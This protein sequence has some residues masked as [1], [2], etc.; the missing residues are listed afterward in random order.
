MRTQA[1]VLWERGAPWSI[2]DVDLAPPTGRGVLVELAASG[3]CH[4]DDHCVTGDM[5]V[6]LPLIGGHEGAGTVLEVGPDASRVRPGDHVIL[7]PLPSCGVCRWC[8]SGRANLCDAGAAAMSPES[9]DGV[10]RYDVKG[11]T[12]PSFVHLGTFSR[13]VVVSEWQ[14]VPIDRDIPLDVASL[15]GCGVSTGW[16]AAVKVA[17]VAPGDTVVVVGVGG[18]GVNAVQ[19]ARLSGASLIMAVDPIAFRRDAARSLGAD[20]AV[21]SVEEAAGQLVELTRGVM[22]DKVIVCVGVLYGD[23]VGPITELVSKGGRLVITSVTPMHET[24]VAMGLGMF[25]MTNKSLLGHVFG[26][27]NP[28]ADFP[29]ILGLYRAGA[30]RLDE[31]ITRRYALAQINEGYADMH[32]GRTVRGLIEHR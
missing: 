18:V 7:T 25:A 16:G 14:T 28:V 4:S 9:Y 32:A 15:I 26:Q 5:P 19:G 23:L 31:L 6:P 2:E 1:A 21:A 17:E 27:V 10:Y 11:R 3:L 30:L 12:V 22:A 24:S 29:R 8:A 20:V 13:Y